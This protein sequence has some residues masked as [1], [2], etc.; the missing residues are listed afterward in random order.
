MR[1]AAEGLSN[2]Y[3]LQEE[4]ARVAGARLAAE[5]GSLEYQVW[6]IYPIW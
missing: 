2:S 6:L 1:V 5:A 4:E 3:Y